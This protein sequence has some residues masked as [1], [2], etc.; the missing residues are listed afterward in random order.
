MTI[1]SRSWPRALALTLALVGALVL[2]N[3]AQ[4]QETGT[5]AEAAKECTG[6]TATPGETITCAFRVV[7]TGDDP[8]EVTNLTETSPVGGTPVDISCT[9]AGGAVINEGDILA[10]D[11]PCTGTFQV[12]IPTNPALCGTTVR[13]RVDISLL[14]PDDDT[15][16]AFAEETTR[17]VCPADIT[18]TKTADALSKV[19]D[20]VTY[21]FRICNAGEGVVTR[22]TVTDT[23]LGNL[24]EFFPADL[25]PDECAT[26]T[27]TRTVQ[28]GDPD[29]LPNTVT[30]KYSTG[31]SSDTATASASTNL[32]QPGVD[33][34]K[35]CAPDPVEVGAA[36]VCTIVVTNTSSSD[37]PN[38][39]SGTITDS[40]TGNLLSS[41]NTAVTSSNCTATLPTGGTC[42][43]VTT[44]TVL[45]S[46]PNPLVNTVTVHYKPAEFP[47][48]ITD[49]ASDSVAVKQ[50][51][52]KEGCTPGYWKQPQHFDSW[53]GYTP[54]QSF[55]TVFNVDVTL[56]GEGQTTYATPTL[57]QALGANGGG[58]N[59][60]AR[61]AVA[62]LLNAS[63]PDVEYA[64]TTAE[65]IALVHNAI[66]SG[67]P[68]QIA[69]VQAL[70][71][72]ANEAGCPLS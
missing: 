16:G 48:D 47:N 65:V 32:F 62:A 13:D 45:A 51:P 10:P 20:S 2:A 60:L 36:L 42:T 3:P 23:L 58:V 31:A 57:L 28:A 61:H 54:S 70:L 49:S 12:T 19:G 14:Y 25:D 40:L 11:T 72:A 8:A 35:N 71:A 30:A 1:A 17:I 26:V 69:E 21:T 63:N 39:V 38:L 50:P 5:G 64:Y 43:I 15:A 34:T 24:A 18:I 22:D 7:N 6:L 68:A 27:R 67:D 52:G 4:A 56:R 29:P 9:I 41:T 66:A 53:V 46:D 37:S 44:R 33:V 59:A 55:E